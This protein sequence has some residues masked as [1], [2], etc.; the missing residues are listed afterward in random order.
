VSTPDPPDRPAQVA[1]SG[2]EDAGLLA[3]YRRI[4]AAA[5]LRLE[6]APVEDIPPTPPGEEVW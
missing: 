4:L 5:T 3:A 2:D 6:A 1:P